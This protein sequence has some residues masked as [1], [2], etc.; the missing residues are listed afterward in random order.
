MPRIKCHYLDC[1]FLDEGICSAGMV[2]LDPDTGCKTYSANAE[3]A[4]EDDWDTDEEDE[5]EE[6]EE[7]DEDEDEELWEEDDS[8]ESY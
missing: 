5:M 3:S 7:L 8:E 6:W 2:E 1:A 4:T